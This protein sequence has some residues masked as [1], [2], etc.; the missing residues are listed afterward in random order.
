[1]KKSL[2]WVVLLGAVLTMNS[3]G[4]DDPDPVSPIVGTWSRAEY[5]LTGLPTGFTKY[6]EGYSLTS[7]GE[8]GYTFVFKEDGTYT[9][10]VTPGISDK[11]KWTQT[12]ANLKVSPD[13]PDKQDQI[14]DAGFI[15]LEFTVEGEV[16]ETRMEL[17]RIMTLGLPSDAAVDA[18]GGNVDDVPNEEWKSV[19][20]TVVYKFNRLN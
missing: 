12:D 9:R 7:F 16:S 2:V 20:V 14:E 18:A 11:G 1:M 5:E 8:T 19:D 4:G 13:D 6:W 15:G 10:A 3:C 17:T